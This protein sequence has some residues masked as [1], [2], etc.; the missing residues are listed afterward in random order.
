MA[1][2][3]LAVAVPEAEPLVRELVARWEPSY[4]VGGAGD[5][6]AHITVLSPFVSPD[7]VEDDLVAALAGHFRSVPSFRYQL[8]EVRSFPGNVVYLAPDAPELFR[9]LTASTC[10][11]FPGYLPYGGKYPSVT[12]HMTVGPIQSDEMEAALRDAGAKAVPLSCHAREVRLIVNDHQSF[13][14]VE[15]FPLGGAM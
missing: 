8:N 9:E 1:H 14:T 2:T 6:L 3:L 15:R 11:R 13:Q 7:A 5:L 12:P 4:D 10:D